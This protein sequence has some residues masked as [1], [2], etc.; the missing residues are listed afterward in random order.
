MRDVP[1]A[2][3][4]SLMKARR[5]P[6]YRGDQ[7]ARWL[8]RDAVW[9]WDDMRNLPRH[10]R[11]GLAEDHD[12]QGLHPAEHQVS[13]DG[14]RKYLYT[15]R[16]D[17]RIESVIIPM[18]SHATFC[19]S[20][21]VGCG[22]ACS[23]CATARGG[24]VRNLSSGE[25]IEQVL[26][27]ADDLRTEP[28]QV[29]G[30]RGYNI[31]FMGM[32]EPLDNLDAVE[33][34]IATF[35]NG[36]GL[37]MSP[38]RITISTSGHVE[39]LMR[40]I[41]SAMTVGLTI[42]VNSSRPEL[43]RRLMPVPGRTPLAETL[44]L[45]ERYAQTRHRRVTIAYV[46]MDGIND[47]DGEASAL[48]RILAGRPFKVNLIPMNRIDGKQGPPPAERVLGFQARL[49]DEGVEAY[50]RISGGDDI[51]AACGQLRD[52]RGHEKKL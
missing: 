29:L 46:L 36:Q 25:I 26:R 32:G 52:K 15:L 3:L 45:A 12:L 19:I 18:E 30:D 10:L 23:F 6:E 35:V 22:M 34:A 33:S 28:R 27:L 44:E 9:H 38:R 31:V 41:S 51:A 20:S 4:R 2:E 5:E 1:V 14:T 50:V 37:A 21:Q 43:R 11:D 7:L 39:G 8:Y 42:S 47:G 48:A 24:L 13:R 16:D 40:L 49:R 17:H